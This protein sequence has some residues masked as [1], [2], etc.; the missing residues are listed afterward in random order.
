MNGR[1][2]MSSLSSYDELLAPA[3]KRFDKSEAVRAL[4]SN[5]DAAFCQYFLIYF[6]ALGVHMTRPVE[7][8]I[9]RAAAR[10][11]S[12]GLP[13]LGRT[14]AQHASAEADHHLLMIADLKSLAAL[15]ASPIDVEALLA[16]SPTPGVAR[17]CRLHEENIKGATPFAQVAIEYEIEMLPLRYGTLVVERAVK[18]LGADILSCLSF[19]TKHIA[20]DGAHT[21][22]NARMLATLIAR[23][24]DSL[25][26]LAAAGSAALDAY[27]EF[28][29]DCVSLAE[30][31]ARK[32]SHR[33]APQSSLSWRLKPPP[34]W[35]PDFENDQAT[36]DWLAE[37]RALRGKALFDRGRRP[38]FQTQEGVFL[39]P[40]PIDFYAFHILA[41]DGEKLVGCVRVYRFDR[42]G[43]AC[44]VEKILG[45]TKY[46]Q[47]FGQASEIVEIGR[48]VIDPEYG[49]TNRDFGLCIQLAAASG[50]L[51]KAIGEASG[52]RRG[53]AIC[54]AGTKDRQDAVLT[55]MG[56]AP[57]PGLEPIRRREY[58]DDVRIL[59]CSQTQRLNARF[60]NQIEQMA[61]KIGVEQIIL[62]PIRL[63][64][65]TGVRGDASSHPDHPVR[66]ADSNCNRA[67]RPH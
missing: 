5:E 18:L 2:K 24:P 6:C 8:W 13:R 56:M 35:T 61:K 45:G 47:L 57:V 44:I 60:V 55:R 16:C 59:C 42:D 43:P 65:R 26:A 20:L 66:P 27:T 67:L 38:A 10:C 50:A 39:D 49:A 23:A 1:R 28:L 4:R 37:V 19:V 51:A 34:R 3:R 52:T 36:P 40:D 30:E 64:R 14:L 62:A 63:R 32:G 22:S 48:W 53:Y 25:S 46:R 11:T 58:N 33:P 41:C 54:A 7:G 15:T 12:M 21:D 9:R 17:Y 29:S 31:A